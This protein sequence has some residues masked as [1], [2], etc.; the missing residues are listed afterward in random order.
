M[1]NR[2]LAPAQAS[3]LFKPAFRAGVSRSPYERRHDNGNFFRTSDSFV[4]RL[5][6]NRVKR[7]MNRAR[8]IL[9]LLIP[10]LWLLASMEC[11]SNP[12]SGLKD[13]QPG[14]GISERRHAERGSSTCAHSLEQSAR[15]WNRRLNVQSGPDG[16]CGP[17]VLSQS[18]F[19]ALDWRVVPSVCCHLPPGLA[20]CWQF[21]WRTALEP[22]APSRA[23]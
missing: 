12:I 13:E 1:R 20:N 23:S 8:V 6:A 2:C 3:T 22:R 14:S 16:L 5:D 15:R 10:A 19:L 9:A 4:E 18:Q 11:L 21:H 7:T 17:A